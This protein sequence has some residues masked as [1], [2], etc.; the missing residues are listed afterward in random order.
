MK[1][2]LQPSLSTLKSTGK[3]AFAVLLLVLAASEYL[4]RGPIQFIRN[5]VHW[6][7]ICEVYFP[8]R[9]WI[10]G[11]NPYSPDVFIAESREAAN[12]SMDT[13]DIR[14]YSPYPLTSLAVFSPVSSIPWAQARFV[15]VLLITLA[16]GIMIWSLGR[17]GKLTSF[18]RICIF[19]AICLGLAP[20]HTGVA[21]GN[22]S[23]LAIILSCIAVY[24]ASVDKRTLASILFAIAA[25]LKRQLGIFFSL[26]YL[27]RKEFR[28][29]LLVSV[30]GARF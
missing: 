10:K 28:I 13:N 11:L 6:T 8:S 21:V 16:M 2:V 3:K 29:V 24:A 19:S 26:Y 5:S 9:A 25:C 22:V 17:M 7:D 4:A 23:I 18:F 14:A 27:L 30:F 1:H 20:L 12:D 15:W